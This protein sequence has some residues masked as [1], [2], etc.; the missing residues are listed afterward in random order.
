[1]QDALL[2]ALVVVNALILFFLIKAMREQERSR[3][4][5]FSKALIRETRRQLKGAETE[6]LRLERQNIKNT[7]EYFEKLAWWEITRS[8]YED[9]LEGNQMV[10][11]GR[12]TIDEAWARHNDLLHSATYVLT[13]VEELRAIRDNKPAHKR[14]VP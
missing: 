6:K 4:L 14:S 11:N 12:K 5:A 13:R 2:I 8:Q 7:D 9:L 1:M 3:H 10:L